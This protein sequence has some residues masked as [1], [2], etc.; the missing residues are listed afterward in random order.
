[1][2]PAATPESECVESETPFS[3]L[4]NGIY[5]ILL[6]AVAN[7]LLEAVRFIPWDLSP[8]RFL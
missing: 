3:A 1:V 2:T 8:E 6:V 7:G 4:G 5:M